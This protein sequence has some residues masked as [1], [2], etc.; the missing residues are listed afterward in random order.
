MYED[1]CLIA[2]YD[3]G[4]PIALSIDDA[5][6]TSRGPCPDRSTIRSS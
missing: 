4:L 2:S 6:V 1:L 5:E 3:S